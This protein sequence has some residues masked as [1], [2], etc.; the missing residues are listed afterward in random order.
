MIILQQVYVCLRHSSQMKHLKNN[1]LP[2]K[3]LAMLVET[4]TFFS[5][6]S[7]QICI[8]TH[9]TLCPSTLPPC[10]SL[11]LPFYP[12]PPSSFPPSLSY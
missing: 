7:Y 5:E 4:E 2:V 6:A 10:S 8:V 3:F 11:P 9:T 1:R 12:T